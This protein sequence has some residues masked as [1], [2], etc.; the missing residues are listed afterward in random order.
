MTYT[1]SNSFS[2]SIIYLVSALVC[3]LRLVVFVCV[4]QVLCIDVDL[5]L[6]LFT[7]MRSKFAPT[8]TYISIHVGWMTSQSR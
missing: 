8:S 1:N 6:V 2:K 5:A 3:V 7:L 4:E